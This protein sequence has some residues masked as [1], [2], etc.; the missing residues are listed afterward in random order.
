VSPEPIT[1]LVVGYFPGWA[2]HAQNYHVSDIPGDKLTHV[3]YAF[4]G[5]SNNGECVSIRPQDD[6]I[7]FPLL[8]SLKQQYANLRTL[9]SV[10]GTSHS[11]NFAKMAE[12]A[13]GRSAFA[14]TCITYMKGEGFDG[15]DI[16]WEFPGPGDKPNFTVLLKELR[17]Q[18]DAQAAADRMHY[19]LTAALPAEPAH[20]SNIELDEIHQYLDWVNLMTYDFYTASSRTTHF[21]A[22]LSAA[23]GDPNPDP[24]KRSSYN[25][26]A[27]VRAYLSAGV[28]SA[29]VIVGVPF[30]G[31]GWEGVP[32]LNHGLYQAASRPA[33]G[34]WTNDGIFD[35]KDLNNNYVPTYLRFWSAEASAPWLYNPDTQIM[36]TYDDVQSVS[37][38]A[39]YVKTNKL[40][41]MMIWPLSADDARSSLVDALSGRL[42]PPQA[43][44]PDPG[45]FA[46]LTNSK[47]RYEK[48]TYTPLV[49]APPADSEPV[50]ALGLAAQ[51]RA[52]MISDAEFIEL[53]QRVVGTGPAAAVDTMQSMASA[54][55]AAGVLSAAA[56]LA[57][58]SVADLH[59]VSAVLRMMRSEAADTLVGGLRK[60]DQLYTAANAG[61]ASAGP[62]STG[63]AAAPNPIFTVAS[64]SPVT[65]VGTVPAIP[66][67]ATD[68]ALADRMPAAPRSIEL[69]LPRSAQ[70]APQAGG[71]AFASA[72][73]QEATT[74][75]RL[76]VSLVGSPLS[77][78]AQSVVTWAVTN[79]PDQIRPLL[80]MAQTY[81]A[82]PADAGAT[83]IMALGKVNRLRLLTELFDETLT[84]RA[85]QPIGLLHLERLEMTPLGIERGE[86]SYSL[87]LAPN[88]KV[89]LAHREWSVREEQFSQFI[90]DYMANFSERGVAQTDDIAMSTSTQTSH[91]DALSMNQ[92]VASANGVHVT[93]PVDTTKAASSAVDDTTTKEESK[94][95][96][97]TVTA[98]AS[99]RTMKDHKISFTVTTVSGM[100][101]FTAHLIEN[102]HDDK[103]MR[104]DYFK[105]V[106]KWQSDLYRYGVRLTY[107]VVLPDPGGRLR[108]REIELQAI[109][110]ELGTEF[111]LELVPSDVQVYNWEQLA[112][113]YGVVIPAP[114]DQVQQ[115]EVTL[116]LTYPTP[117]EVHNAGDGTAFNVAQRETSLQL[118]IPQNFQLQNLN[119][120][121][122]V[123]TW[124]GWSGWSLAV[125]VGSSLT[126][127]PTVPTL[128]AYAGQSINEAPPPDSNG[129]MT[130]DWDLGPTQVPSEGQITV[131]FRMAAVENGIL[132]LTA[133]VVP[134]E[135]SMEE[136]RLTCWST[137]RDAAAAAAAQHRSYLRD[138]QSALQ[139]AIAADDPLRLR[140]MEREAVM[141]LVLEWLFPG[142][143]DASSV[144]ATL[145]S[146]GSLDPGTWQQ[147][148]EYGEYIKFVQT[149]I[150]WDNV[151]VFLYPYFW[152]TIWHEQ[153]KLFLDHPDAVHREFLR[154]GAAR[155]VLAVEPGFEDQVVSLLDQGQLGGLGEQSRFAK[156][157]Q[158]VQAANAA[159]AKTTQGGGR[160]EDP[161]EPGVLIGSWTDYTPSSALDIDVTLKPLLAA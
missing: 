98:L 49:I 82:S 134:T 2:I 61:A 85:L 15:I 108:Q 128:S 44:G 67:A 9:I 25:V 139:R 4:A 69:G 27:A 153:Q 104:I 28:P 88:E 41:G 54:V 66:F 29:K 26:D 81:V 156:V 6:Q 138:R 59:S 136:W 58:V 90:E 158:D 64:G 130:L 23:S 52:L 160:C 145:P 99:T 51:A 109:L 155:V 144:L 143:E 126:E 72:S 117:Y 115:I 125:T 118:G 68:H 53:R 93:S 91:N 24:K 159:Y 120:F 112:D 127:M 20:Y 22:P 5:V 86:L 30:I 141:R 131:V 106:R 89:T 55:S 71:P 70:V 11:N 38:K 74:A 116:P 45:T 105:R 39:D 135:S 17:E 36:I 65:A 92:P 111:R 62:A 63:G 80:E 13:V 133:T 50:G 154:A 123:F 3:N 21:A 140:R 16:D 129:Y 152:D 124:F 46:R 142:F 84:Q 79:Q 114:P 57:K 94:A 95:Q 137:I 12:K 33:H 119:V 121:G 10:G 87:P 76:V 83:V 60:I 113:Q 43:T 8:Q 97:R 34:T 157:I 107:D 35:F 47:R 56:S 151:M 37:L 161:R 78:R 77:Q 149:A 73:A 14:K 110:D 96:S 122:Q 31:H 147:V 102:K 18:L 42:N 150:D 7:N 48:R 146:P 32:N 101:D 1:K 132:R 19:L 103:S 40:G 148:M 100:E 75:D